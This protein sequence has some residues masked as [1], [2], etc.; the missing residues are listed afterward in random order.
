MVWS[1]PWTPRAGRLWTVA[2]RAQGFSEGACAR[3]VEGVSAPRAAATAGALPA[4]LTRNHTRRERLRAGKVRDHP[5]RRRLRRAGHTDRDPVLH[6]EL[7]EAGE[8]R[9]DMAVG[10]DAEHQHVELARR[11]ARASPR[12]T[13]PRPPRRRRRPRRRASRALSRVGSDLVEQRPAR[14]AARCGRGCRAR[15]SAR[16]PT[17]REP[18]AQSTADPGVRRAI[19]RCTVSAMRAARQPDVRVP[20]RRLGGRD[21][22]R[23]G[24][25][26]H[27]RRARPRRRRP[28]GTRVTKQP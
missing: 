23:A 5:L 13:P 8:E 20:A 10:S 17:R 4:P 15:R 28:R 25:G 3:L 27:R 26:D 14:L 22:R 24:G 6:V 21:S 19:S 16:R 2:P 9:G 1:R 18:F 11:P 12:R 7:R